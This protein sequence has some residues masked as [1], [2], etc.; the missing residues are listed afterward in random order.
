MD[1]KKE[2]AELFQKYL[3]K[4]G[5][6]CEHSSYCDNDECQYDKR[7][8]C[9]VD[10]H[11]AKDCALIDIQNRI[12]LIK[13]ILDPKLD[14]HQTLSTPVRLCADFL[15]PRLK[16]YEAIKSELEKL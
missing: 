4:V 7:I 3:S 5:T 6:N 8:V 1:Y 9:C 14:F 16:K 15:N 10:L 11:T 13:E 2:S 12:D